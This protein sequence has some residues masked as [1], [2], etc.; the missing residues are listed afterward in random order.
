M[1]IRF[2]KSIKMGPFRINLSKKGIGASIGVPGIRTGIKADGTRY[3]ETSIPGTGIS[4]RA[5]HKA[6]RRPSAP[7][8]DPPPTET[9]AGPEVDTGSPIALV[10]IFVVIA[11]LLLVGL[12]L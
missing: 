4:S 1:A 3:T 9:Q 7:T 10:V 11:A 6:A 8:E 2:R 5:E 12:A